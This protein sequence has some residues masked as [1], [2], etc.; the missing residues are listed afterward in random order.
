[1]TR[2]PA[3]LLLQRLSHPLADRPILGAGPLAHSPDQALGQLDG[4][5]VFGFGNGQRSR[6]LLGSLN[7]A[8]SL[9]GGNAELSGQARD[10]FG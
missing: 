1:M 5:D 10:D 3:Q 7:V 4:E 9:A 2:N 8:S 6:L